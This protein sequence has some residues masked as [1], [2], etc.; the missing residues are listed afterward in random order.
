[1]SLIFENVSYEY[2]K[3]GEENY[4]ALDNV[5]FE[6]P[7]SSIY[8][9][10]GETGSGKSTLMRLFNGIRKP[11]SGRVLFNGDD[12]WSP[13]YDRA[14]LPFKVG[15]VFQY[16]ES[17]LFEESVIKD[18]SFGPINMGKNKEEALSMAKK[19]LE[20]VGIKEDKWNK[21]PFSLS[22]GEKRRVALAGILAMNPEVLVLDEIAAGLDQEGHDRIFSLLEELKSKG[23]TVV[24]V[25]HS[26]DDVA[27]YADRVL[28]LRK[29]R[30]IK[31]GKPREVFS[32]QTIPKPEV[33]IIAEKLRKK[34]INIPS[35]ILSLDELISAIKECKSVV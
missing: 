30:V 2:K 18:V 29:G 14:S 4:K 12:I 7:S 1:M 31:E 5:S 17:E 27:L 33:E 25:S 9:I 3:F 24:F 10:M 21:S 34:G 20:L 15:L 11:E 23:K 6:I 28:V 16:P 32:S 26:P 35:P 13:S 19:A 8:A 22:G